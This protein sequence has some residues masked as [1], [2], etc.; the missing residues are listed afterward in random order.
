MKK[1]Q[2]KNLHL[3]RKLR[4]TSIIQTTLYE[5]METVIDI[6]GSDEN[7]LVKEV[8]LNLLAKAKTCGRVS[9]L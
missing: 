4:C 5:L 2:T 9:G 1:T 6:V 7:R 3:S 8:T